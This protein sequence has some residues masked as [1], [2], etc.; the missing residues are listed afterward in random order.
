MPAGFSFVFSAHAGPLMVRLSFQDSLPWSTQLGEGN[1]RPIAAR[2]VVEDEGESRSLP[3][4]LSPIAPVN[5]QLPPPY[6]GP[7]RSAEREGE[8]AMSGRAAADHRGPVHAPRR[9]FL[10]LEISPSRFNLN[11]HSRPT[12][13]GDR[14]CPQRSKI[15]TRTTGRLRKQLSKL[16]ANCPPVQSALKP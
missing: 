16:L 8:Q 6:K 10:F 11:G 12:T 14:P 1:E 7:G 2:N 13:L 3:K 15:L 5:A 4:F 9:T